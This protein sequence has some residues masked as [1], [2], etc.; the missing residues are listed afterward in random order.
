MS[1]LEMTRRDRKLGDRNQQNDLGAVFGGRFAL[2]RGP[3]SSISPYRWMSGFLF[4][5]S[6]APLRVDASGVSSNS[7][8]KLVD[9]S[10]GAERGNVFSSS[11][12]GARRGSSA[13]AVPAEDGLGTGLVWR[14]GAL[15]TRYRPREASA[16][17]VSG[18]AGITSRVTD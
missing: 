5:E 10:T 9:L 2:A 14:D 3:Q 8:L 11:G 6:L 15:R 16:D 12:R 13:R 17:L 18:G 4:E 7:Y 1:T